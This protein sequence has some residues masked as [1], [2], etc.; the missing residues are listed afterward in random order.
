MQYITENTSKNIIM[1]YTGLKDKNGIEIYEGDVV[2]RLTV[3]DR[4]EIQF[5]EGA[6]HLAQLPDNSETEPRDRI[7]LYSTSEYHEVIGNIYENP[8]L[9]GEENE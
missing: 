6:W 7:E 4:W 1:Q 9:I 5:F 2:R 8:E 3:L